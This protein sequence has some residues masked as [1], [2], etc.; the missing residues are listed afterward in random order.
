M[1]RLTPVKLPDPRSRTSL[2][3]P[4]YL[5]MAGIGLLW[6]LLRGQVNPWRIPEHPDPS[7]VTG[8][9]VGIGLGLGLVL[10]SRLSVARYGWARWLEQDFRHRLGRLTPRE[11]WMLAVASSV[12]EEILF[13]GALLP[14][15]GLWWSSLI[16][17]GMHMGPFPRYLPWTGSALVA[18]LAFGQLHRWSGDLTG[19]VLAHFLV[20]YLNLRHLGHRE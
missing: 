18:G 2:A 6:S 13:R 10:A 19:P 7:P 15:T 3:L 12:G 14:A 16:F 9:L 4:L 17:A 11:C 20:N 5:M 8:A 1:V